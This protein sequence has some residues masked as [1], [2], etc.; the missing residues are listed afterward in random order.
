MRRL[1]TF[2]GILALCVAALIVPA[3]AAPEKVVVAYVF[4]ENNAL[5]VGQVDGRRIT[6]INYAFANIVDG[7]HALGS[8]RPF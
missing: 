5:Q 7:R 6:R 4:P 8:R 2:C 1:G 3:Y